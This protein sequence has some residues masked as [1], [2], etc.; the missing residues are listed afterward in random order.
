MK[1]LPTVRPA[2]PETPDAA[3]APLR[4]WEL[5]GTIVLVLGWFWLRRG[6]VY[7]HP[8]DS[9]ETQH[10][11]VVWGWTQGLIPYRD[12][13]DNHT[14]LFHILF[15]P[16]FSILGERPDIVDL[17]RW[18][19]V[20]LDALVAWCTYRIGAQVFSRR[21]GIVAAL[22]CAFYPNAYF[23]MG[24]FRTD[25]LWTLLWL[26]TLVLL[27]KPRLTRGHRF[28]AG[29][30]FGATFATSQKTV[31]L[32]LVL[33]AASVLTCLLIRASRRR[34]ATPPGTVPS[35]AGAYLPALAAAGQR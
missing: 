34:P 4:R 14:P 8:W 3:G 18:Y 23:K 22:L 31:L 13:F 11:H 20:A 5:V 2:A 1:T 30:T 33:L 10:L 7:N 26:A 32:A 17:G 16:I 19:M 25:V 35:P 12:F 28:L 29:L 9:D 24:E 15:A 21:I 27:T 6:S